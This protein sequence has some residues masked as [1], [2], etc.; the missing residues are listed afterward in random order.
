MNQRRLPPD[1]AER[2]A[3]SAA[4]QAAF[5]EG[6]LSL[7]ELEARLEEVEHAARREEIHAALA[8][9]PQ[10]GEIVPGAGAL[11]VRAVSEGAPLV[12]RTMAARIHYGG[13]LTL[14]SELSL[15][16]VVGT[17]VLDLSEARWEGHLVVRLSAVAGRVRVIVPPDVAV[18]CEGRAFVGSLPHLQ[19]A[20]GERGAG[21]QRQRTLALVGNLWFATL[22]VEVRQPGGMM[23]KVRQGLRAF[24]PPPR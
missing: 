15:W 11:R 7:E 10:R 16:T 1:D 20:F 18:A 19:G 4:L 12:W 22:V 9:V 14:P 17:S 6:H 21:R 23:A 24:L 5:A 13:A 2:A 8:G 3:A